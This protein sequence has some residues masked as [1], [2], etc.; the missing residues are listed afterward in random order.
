MLMHRVEVPTSETV[1]TIHP[2][3]DDKQQ[4]QVYGAALK[5]DPKWV[6]ALVL[7]GEL[8]AKAGEKAAAKRHFDRAVKLRPDDKGLR[9]R[10]D[11]LTP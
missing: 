2:P 11:A 7:L 1:T 9:E 4:R 10:R 3:D 8:E 6:S 5:V